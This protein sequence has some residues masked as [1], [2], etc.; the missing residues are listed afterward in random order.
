M[1]ENSNKIIKN[2][3]FIYIRM[4]ISI[5]VSL[6]SVRIVLKALGV[7]D[8]GIYSLVGG[9]IAFLS[10]LNGAMTTSSQRYISFFLG[11]NNLKET[12]EIFKSTIFLHLAI[13][14][15]L[16]VLFEIIGLFIFD[17][18]LNIPVD[19]IDSAKTVYQFMILNMFVVIN[20][21]PY[22][23]L[24]NSREHLFFD[25]IVGVIESLL[26]LGIAIIL[27]YYSKDRLVFYAFLLV[28]LGMV[29]RLVKF[30]YCSI[31]FEES[32]VFLKKVV[33][34]YKL[35]KEM[36]S[37]ASWNL[38]GGITTVSYTQ[39]LSIILNL[40]FGPVVNAS[41]GIGLQISSQLLSFS[42]SIIKAINP[43]IIKSEGRGERA[44]LIEL[45]IKASK[46]SFFLLSIICLPLIF[47][48]NYVLTMWLTDVP[49]YSVLFCQLIL[50]R[51]MIDQFSSG[52]KTAIQAVGKIKKYQLVVGIIV[53]MNIPT[54]YILLHFGL[55][56]FWVFINSIALSILALLVRLQFSKKLI[57]LDFMKFY[58]R[59]IKPNLQCIIIPLITSALIIYFFDESFLRLLT[60]S[61]SSALLI[62]LVFY[63]K[64]L[65][66]SEKSNFNRLVLKFL[67]K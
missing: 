33:I 17:G 35:F 8:F 38:F 37:F 20:S 47:E 49:K 5:V 1:N 52:I 22:D 55:Q 43:Q 58:Q 29:I 27:T 34:N 11:R 4:V 40:F 45:T 51:A 63:T 62:T 3:I 66:L 12:R 15:I 26:K 28:V 65:S 24:I 50:I 31:N 30:L 64:G 2:T 48:M 44:N 42:S 32:K 41:Y 57:G 18:V 16:V 23:S 25:S 67:R 13:S 60:L 53:I 59:I 21:V 7:V 9:V 19:R 10:F 14:L 39:G 61:L 56:P 54:S 46:F 36:M 6:Y